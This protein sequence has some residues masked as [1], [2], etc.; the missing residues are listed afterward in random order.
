MSLVSI[1]TALGPKYSFE[2]GPRGSVAWR[3]DLAL[4]LRAAGFDLDGVVEFATSDLHGRRA[5]GEI[6]IGGERFVVRRYHH[7]G[8][9]RWLTGERFLDSARPFREIEL[10]SK[11]ASLGFRTP[12]VVAARALAAQGGGWR[13]DVVARRVEDS[14][15]LGR[16]C[17][18][19]M[20]CE[21]ADRAW[22]EVWRSTGSLVRRLHDRGV[23]HAD[24]TPRNL[25][26]ERAEL[27][28]AKCEPWV[29]DLDRTVIKGTLDES[30]KLANLRRL[31]RHVTRL[32]LEGR[33]SFTNADVARFLEAYEP[34]SEKRRE[35]RR[36]IAARATR[37]SALHSAGWSLERRLGGRRSDA[38]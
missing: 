34:R 19:R 5:L 16:L 10:A 33:A 15:D 38:T 37:N 21:V 13:L 27:A 29:I 12:D 20:R 30:E 24:L 7:G 2:T 22:R 32:G 26:V 6:R 18:E 35:I 31:F 4:E 1:L 25:L 36:A 9:L 14:L 8:L 28:L 11:V 3:F 23:L 17:A